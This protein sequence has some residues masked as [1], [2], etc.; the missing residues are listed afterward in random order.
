MNCRNFVLS[1]FS[2]MNGTFLVSSD[3]FITINDIFIAP[4]LVP[5]VDNNLYSFR[6]IESSDVFR[7]ELDLTRG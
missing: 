4:G 3:D 6:T 2:S 7:Y 1:V 5:K